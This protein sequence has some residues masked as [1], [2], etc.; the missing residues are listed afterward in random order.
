MKKHYLYIFILISSIFCFQLIGFSQE[1]TGS[2][3][4]VVVD[5]TDAPLAGVEVVLKGKG[6]S[7]RQETYSANRTGD[8]KF[9][10]LVPGEYEITCSLE[11]FL[12]N[13]YV[14]LPVVADKILKINVV[15]K[16]ALTEEI[17]VK[18]Y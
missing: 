14:G 8:F 13:R 9:A 3:E 1:K 2:I 7:A 4:G 5:E 10:D 17:I 6:P 12:T 15:L 16:L 11:G 18:E